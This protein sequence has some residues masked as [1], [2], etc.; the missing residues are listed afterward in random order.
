MC[1]LSRTYTCA[2][3]WN[4]CTLI[5]L[6]NLGESCRACVLTHEGKSQNVLFLAQI[7]L[8]SL[9]LSENLIYVFVCLCV[10]IHMNAYIYIYTYL[11][12][13]IY[14]IYIYMYIRIPAK[15]WGDT[16]IAER[17]RSVLVMRARYRSA[18]LTPHQ[19]GRTDAG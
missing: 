15:K 9:C 16:E 14:T 3:F 13:Y 10:H 4:M 1:P 19:R 8:H 11:H 17:D 7:R 6:H 5:D 18:R 12:I 2:F